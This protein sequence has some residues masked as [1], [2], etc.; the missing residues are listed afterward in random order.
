M[1]KYYL[2]NKE[3][4]VCRVEYFM[5]NIKMIVIFLLV[6]TAL[7][8][9]SNIWNI[10][11]FNMFTT[12]ES[13]VET[14]YAQEILLPNEALV[15]ADNLYRVAYNTKENSIVN[16]SVFNLLKDVDSSGVFV[17]EDTSEA[18]NTENEI[19]ENQ[20]S[21]EDLI[22]NADIIYEYCYEI[23]PELIAEV[24]NTKNSIFDKYN[25]VF[26]Y[27]FVNSEMNEV[28]F[29][30]S[31]NNENACFIVDGLDLDTD[32]RFNDNFAFVYNDRDSNYLTPYVLNSEFVN[33]EETNPYSENNEILVSTVESKI[34]QFFEEP[35]EKWTIFGEDCYIFSG[36][37]ITVK[38]Y[39]NNILEYRD[40]YSSAKKV[41]EAT[42][43]AI[44]KTFIADDDLVSNDL[45]L[46]D[47]TKDEDSYTFYFNP[48]VNNTEVVF[49]NDF[50]DYY[51]EIKVTNGV[52]SQYTKYVMNYD[53]NVSDIRTIEKTVDIMELEQHFDSV[54][55][56]YLQDMKNCTANLSWA[57]SF[58][59]NDVY[60]TME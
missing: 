15:K 26:N 48:V 58:G 55:F 31:K 47:V 30:N 6:I 10:K 34:N 19:L 40:S 35:N 54:G 49:D 2:Y 27:I 8:Q 33:L 29:Y 3:P 4:F 16:Q 51:I 46:K 36:E 59:E 60:T 45:I 11:V 9:L 7:I 13:T 37:D 21:I 18:V 5:K 1:D 50:I 22:Y 42:A 24:F 41:D 25:I 56:V 38:Y 12:N 17:K 39:N 20:N 28:N 52:V 57:M 44:A 43:Y 53:E 23:T 14:D 32:Y